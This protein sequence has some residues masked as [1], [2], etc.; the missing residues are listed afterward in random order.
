MN[1]LK[2][3]QSSQKESTDHTG[4]NKGI[5]LKTGTGTGTNTQNSKQNHLASISLDDVTRY[6]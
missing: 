3:E 1:Y 6:I 5:T 4:T 2:V